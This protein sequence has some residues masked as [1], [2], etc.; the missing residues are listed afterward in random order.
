MLTK[1]IGNYGG[2]YSD[3][4]SRTNPE[5]DMPADYGNRLLED[6]AQMT[7]TSLKALVV[8]N[9][10]SVAAP[11][12][13]TP[14][15]RSQWGSGAAQL[16][17]VAKTATGRYTITF[18]ASYTDALSVVETVAFYSAQAHT[19][20]AD[21]DD[22]TLAQVLTIAGNVITIKTEATPGTLAD[23]GNNSAAVFQVHLWLR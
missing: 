13:V 1:T 14:T 9:T 19:V 16:P 15:M 7:A 6:E 10:T 21:P 4:E 23:V 8:F 22:D 18:P 17:T 11:T 2:P 20:A 5:T 3:F 12:T